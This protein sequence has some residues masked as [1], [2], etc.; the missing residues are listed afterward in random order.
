LCSLISKFWLQQ[1][2]LTD[3]SGASLTLLKALVSPPPTPE[4]NVLPDLIDLPHTSRLYKTL[5]QGGQYNHKTHNVDRVSSSV[6]DSTTFATNFVEE[7]GKEVTVRMCV[8]DGNGA[9]VVSELVEALDRG[10]NIEG[11]ARKRIEDA[12]MALKEWFDK[13]VIKE[14]EQGEAKGKKILLEKLASL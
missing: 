5:L 4:S 2:S 11:D 8:G 9:F 6:W 1:I 13:T 3:K 14:I 10:S 12:R 7:V